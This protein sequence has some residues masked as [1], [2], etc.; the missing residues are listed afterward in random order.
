[1]LGCRTR[2]YVQ[3]EIY[4]LLCSGV[5]SVEIEIIADISVCES[6]QVKVKKKVVNSMGNFVYLLVILINM[7]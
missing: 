6:V 1:M 7:H 5:Y 4:M 2:I 3:S